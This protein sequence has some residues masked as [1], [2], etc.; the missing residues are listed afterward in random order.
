MTLRNV[1]C[2]L[3]LL[4]LP[5][6][7]QEPRRDDPA[8]SFVQTFY[9]WYAPM[10]AKA[11]RGPAFALA[12]QRKPACFSPQLLQALADDAAAQAKVSDDVVGLDFDPFLYSQDP[13]KGFVLGPVVLGPGV[14]KEE[15]FQVPFFRSTASRKRGKPDLVAVV[16]QTKDQ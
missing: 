7:S 13:S 3:A 4:C 12:I 6:L 16:Q 1:P 10:A 14:S 2:L 9:G 11:T 15:G 5:A 8:R